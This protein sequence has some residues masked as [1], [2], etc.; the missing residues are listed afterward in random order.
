M[1]KQYL[2][3]KSVSRHEAEARIRT[4]FGQEDIFIV[5]QGFKPCFHIPATKQSLFED[6]AFV[7]GWQL[8]ALRE[9]NWKLT[10]V[11]STEQGLTVWVEEVN[12]W[13]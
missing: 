4:I 13:E 2:E 8:D 1:S 5:G 12:S 3:G 9:I 11:K 6:G 7:L 10:Q